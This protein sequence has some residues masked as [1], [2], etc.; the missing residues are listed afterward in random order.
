[1]IDFTQALISLYPNCHWEQHGYEYSGLVWK[2]T[3]TP[4]PT[5]EELVTEYN[6][7]Q[8][9]YNSKEYQR[10]REKEYPPMADQLDMIFHGGLDLWKQNIQAIKDKYPKPE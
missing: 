6:R 9:D 7:L 1:M 10:L 4:K 3:N 5:E 2:D 8:A